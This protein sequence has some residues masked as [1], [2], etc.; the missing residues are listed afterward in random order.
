M[1]RIVEFIE[2]CVDQSMFGELSPAVIAELVHM[3]NECSERPTENFFS[4]I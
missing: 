1:E 3:I 2:E 4:S